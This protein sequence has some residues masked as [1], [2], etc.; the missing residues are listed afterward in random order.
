MTCGQRRALHH[1]R[2]DEGLHHH[3]SVLEREGEMLSSTLYM[4]CNTCKS[5]ASYA[6]K[7]GL[8]NEARD[9]ILHRVE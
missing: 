1:C 7:H 3:N 2:L 4:K 9:C 8:V 6:Q 5:R